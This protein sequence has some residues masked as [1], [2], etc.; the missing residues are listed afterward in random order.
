MLAVLF[1]IHLR[2]AYILDLQF[3]CFL[4]RDICSKSFWG[5]KERRNHMVR[6]HRKLPTAWLYVEFELNR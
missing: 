3:E 4:P 1:E 5:P 6:V 2:V